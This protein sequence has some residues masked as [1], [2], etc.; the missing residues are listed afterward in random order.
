MGVKQKKHRCRAVVATAPC[1]QQA[2]YPSVSTAAQET[3][4]QVSRITYACRTGTTYKGIRWMFA[5]EMEKT[6]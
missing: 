4:G 5:E 1:G 3:G 2:V 6:K